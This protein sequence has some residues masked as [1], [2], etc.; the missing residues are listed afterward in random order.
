[1][2]DNVNF[3]SSQ[4]SSK[5]DLGGNLDLSRSLQ[6]GQVDN[7]ALNQMTSNDMVVNEEFFAFISESLKYTMTMISPEDMQ[8]FENKEI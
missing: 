3:G 4:Q 2:R 5:K 1:M 6:Q 7:E 8:L